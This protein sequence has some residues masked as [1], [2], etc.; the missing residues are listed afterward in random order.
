MSVGVMPAEGYQ[1]PVTARLADKVE[2]A[3]SENS[4]K[5]SGPNV[6]SVIRPQQFHVKSET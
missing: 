5:A 6:D 4:L 2:I 1:E 3:S